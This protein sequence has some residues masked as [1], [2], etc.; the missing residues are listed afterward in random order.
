MIHIL[1][2]QVC[3]SSV[4]NDPSSDTSY[5]GR[6]TLQHGPQERQVHHR[7]MLRNDEEAIPLPEPPKAEV[8]HSAGCHCCCWGP[9]EHV[10]NET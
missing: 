10:C 3:L 1:I 5:Q 2:L 6:E 9:V 7:K 8:R 4:C